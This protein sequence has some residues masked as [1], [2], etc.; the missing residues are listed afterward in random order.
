MEE[1]VR[2]LIRRKQC[3]ASEGKYDEL[4]YYKPNAGQGRNKN[5]EREEQA[6]IYETTFSKMNI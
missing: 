4:R 2:N 5:G 6:E 3:H 1:T